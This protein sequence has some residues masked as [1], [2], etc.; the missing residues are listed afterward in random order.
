[1]NSWSNATTNEVT[2]FAIP[3]TKRYAPLATLST[4]DNARL[5]HI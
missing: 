1:M 2:T 4:Q 5:L 3:N